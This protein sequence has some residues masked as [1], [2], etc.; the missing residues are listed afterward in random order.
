MS[1]IHKGNSVTG[2]LGLSDV[3]LVNAIRADVCNNPNFANWGGG[4]FNV[5][6]FGSGFSGKVGIVDV[7]GSATT[8]LLSGKL[9]L[10]DDVVQVGGSF[11]AQRAFN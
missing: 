4:G 6:M 1:L 3:Q 8:D 10:P 7:S 5:Q 2:N 9:S 11:T